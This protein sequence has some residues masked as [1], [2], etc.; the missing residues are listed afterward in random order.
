METVRLIISEN[1]LTKEQASEIMA[2]V[3]SRKDFKLIATNVDRNMWAVR[4]NAENGTVRFSTSDCIGYNSYGI[5]SN[6]ITYDNDF[7]C[8]NGMQINVEKAN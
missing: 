8:I 7:L 4:F 6:D 1:R 3:K 5:T 2:C